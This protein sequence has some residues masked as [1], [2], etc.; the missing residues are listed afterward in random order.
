[1]RFLKKNQILG[2]KQLAFCER[3]QESED[4]LKKIADLVINL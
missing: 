2:E 1:M 3:M 4:S